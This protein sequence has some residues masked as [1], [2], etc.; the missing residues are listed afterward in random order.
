MKQPL[1]LLMTSLVVPLYDLSFWIGL[2]P[3]CKDTQGCSYVYIYILYTVVCESGHNPIT[4]ICTLQAH[5]R[6]LNI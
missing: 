1:E 6:A 4:Y 2:Y 5:R 3:I